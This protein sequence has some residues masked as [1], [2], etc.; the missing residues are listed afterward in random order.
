MK[1]DSGCGRAGIAQWRVAP[2]RKG[3]TMEER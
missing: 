2:R 3:M 1:M